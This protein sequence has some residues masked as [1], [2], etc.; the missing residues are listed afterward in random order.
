[1][2]TATEHLESLTRVV[3]DFPRAGIDFHD[4]TPVL[5]DGDALAVVADALVAPFAGEYDAIAGVEARGFAFAAAAAARAGAGLVLI[6]KAGKLPGATHGEDYELEYGRDRLEVH[7]EQVPAGTR[8]LLV[9]DVLATGGTLAAAGSLV[10]RAGWRIAGVAVVLELGL[11]GG[12][13]ALAPRVPYAL[14]RR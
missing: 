4:L 5:A 10:E 1:M 12:R 6:R 2:P 7:R 9:D 8:V 3:P 14:V 11:L 13:A